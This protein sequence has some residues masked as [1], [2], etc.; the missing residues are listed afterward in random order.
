MSCRSTEK[1]IVDVFFF[2]FYVYHFPQ[3]AQQDTQGLES[4]ELFNF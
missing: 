1:L 2:F 4:D 3:Q